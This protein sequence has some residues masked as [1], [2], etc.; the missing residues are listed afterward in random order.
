VS[1]RPDSEIEIRIAIR[2]FCDKP[3]MLYLEPWGEEYPMELQREF[4]LVG[5]GPQKGS[6]FTVDYGV[7]SI[8]VSGWTGSVVRVF[9]GDKEL[10]DSLKR[11]PVPDFD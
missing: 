4:V 5:H 6:G 3:L 11:P 2:N 10:G 9:C 8:T 7:E 1:A